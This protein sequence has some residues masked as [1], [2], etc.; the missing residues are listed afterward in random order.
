[1]TKESAVRAERRDFSME[2][3]KKALDSPAEPR[4]NLFKSNLQLSGAE[5]AKCGFERAG[6]ESRSAGVREM[7]GMSARGVPSGAGV[8]VNSLFYSDHL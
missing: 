4:Y 7:R 3:F 2:I 1:M 6:A 5:L 8:K